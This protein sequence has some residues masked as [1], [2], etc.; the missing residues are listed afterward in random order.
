MR[1]FPSDEA[2]VRAYWR[3]LTRSIAAAYKS[4]GRVSAERVTHVLQTRQRRASR[5]PSRRYGV[6]AT[7]R[8]RLNSVFIK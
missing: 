4:R 6:A 7:A 2:L 5:P 8:A 3:K 1:S